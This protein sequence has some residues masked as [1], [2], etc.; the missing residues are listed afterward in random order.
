MSSAKRVNL[1]SSL[2]IWMS[3]I[4]FCCLIAEART[5]STTLNNSDESGHPCRVPDLKGRALFFP[6]E[7]DI[8]CRL[9]IDGFSEIEACALYPYTPKGFNQERMPCF[10]KC[11]FCIYREDPMIFGSLSC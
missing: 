2:L 3:F 8:C 11:F 4:S 5:S 1:I 10:V 9:F 6:I 7:N